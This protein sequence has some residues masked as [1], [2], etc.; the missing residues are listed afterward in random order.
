MNFLRGLIAKF[1]FS[2]E[3]T[4]AQILGKCCS[5]AHRAATEQSQGG[6]QPDLAL[7]GIPVSLTSCPF[8]RTEHSGT[9]A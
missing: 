9:L 3:N 2:D 7:L 8:L 1:I 4:E 5:P 6:T